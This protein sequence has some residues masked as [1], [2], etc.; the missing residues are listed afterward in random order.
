MNIKDLKLYSLI[1]N[2]Y[3]N[4]K[5]Q[6]KHNILQH[7]LLRLI[8]LLHSYLHA[9]LTLQKTF[10][11]AASKPQICLPLRL[12]LIKAL[13]FCKQG[14]TFQ[15]SI[16]R[17]SHN[18]QNKTEHRHFFL[19]LRSLQILVKNG[20]KTTHLLQTVKENIENEIKFKKKLKVLT[21]QMRMQA[22]II[23]LSPIIL[24]ALLLLISPEH[25]L[26]FFE[27]TLG[28]LAFLVMIFLNLC[29]WFFLKKIITISAM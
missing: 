14:L 8:D 26:I 3:R 4:L 19:L 16:Q 9:G 28:V 13:G 12:F 6:K 11:Q 7:D 21:A 24:T 22:N 27:S 18:C 25:I 1:K 20:G 15:E 29:G 5:E 17:I 2:I 23:L 10:E